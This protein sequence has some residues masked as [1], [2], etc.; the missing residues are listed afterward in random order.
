MWD[1]G[2][3]G[4]HDSLVILREDRDLSDGHP[5]PLPGTYSH[6]DALDAL[7]EE[8]AQAVGIHFPVLEVLDVCEA[9]A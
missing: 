6:A 7:G 9:L 2:D 4:E 5:G 3:G 1:G 8:C